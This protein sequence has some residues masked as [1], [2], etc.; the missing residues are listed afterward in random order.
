[1]GGIVRINQL[2]DG[3]GNLSNDDI[4]LFMDDPSGSATTKKISLSQISSAIG[5][6][7]GTNF[8]I[9]T[10]DL[11]N[12][13][14]QN[15]QILAFNDPNYQSVITGPVPSSGNNAQRII[16]QGRRGQGNGEGGDVYLWGGDSDINGGDIKIY[17]GDADNNESGN[18][19]YVNIDGG[20]GADNGG[21]VEITGG[22]SEGGQAGS[23]NIVGGPTSSGVAGDVNIKTNNSTNNWVFAPNGNLAIPGNITLPNYTTVASGT[24]DNGT[25]GNGGIS[26]NCIV[27]YEL[28]W[29]GGRLKSTLDNGATAENIY[30]DSPITVSGSITEG[31]VAIGNS[32]SSQVLSL[33]SGTVQTCT[34]DD[35]CTFTMPTGIAGQGFTLFLTQGTGAYSGIFTDVKWP[36]GTPSVVST[37]NAA[38]DIFSFLSDGTY[39]YGV[40]VKNFS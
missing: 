20:K 3:S 14:V 24:F 19:G 15:A 27:G 16:V 6:G 32:S 38:T 37:G 5:S 26:I 22:Y 31:A 1:M 34:L 28:N 33:T 23:V 7:G 13:G 4:F 25:G 18:G 21:D 10:V 9:D 36:G 11:H 40:S 2:P 39:W 30:I 8:T 29:Q 12:G 17:A 35:N